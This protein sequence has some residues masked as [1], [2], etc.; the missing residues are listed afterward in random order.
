M[1]QT[2]NK[3]TGTA[4]QVKK[5]NRRLGAILGICAGLLVLAMV[6]VT[7]VT[8]LQM[9]EE[10][11]HDL[12]STYF[13]PTYE[14]NIMEYRAY[15]DKDRSVRYSQDASGYGLTTSMTE[16]TR[17]E[18]SKEAWFL[19]DYIQTIIAGD[20]TA[21]NTLFNEN[22]YKKND[23]KGAFTPQMIYG[24]S[25]R[26][27]GEEKDGA[28]RLVSFWLEYRIFENDGTFRRDIGSDGTRRQNVVLRVT[29]G[30][31]ISIEKL[32]TDF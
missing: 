12:P 10:K 28:D 29:P 16:E 11:N 14:G 7:V 24:S 15:L 21:Y 2:E 13:Y 4:A 17:E 3:A 19:Y 25:I 26:Y 27:R 6:A 22:Y 9:Q 8:V 31:A 1:E 20:V 32:I 18:F 23:P 5:N 30:G